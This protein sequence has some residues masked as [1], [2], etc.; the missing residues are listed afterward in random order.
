MNKKLLTSGLLAGLVA[1]SGAGLILQSTGF[2][3]AAAAPAAVV[4][5]ATAGT[6]GTAG[7]TDSTARPDPSA[8]LTE[9][10]QPLVDDGTITADQL[11]AIVGALDAAGPMGR[12]GDGPGGRGMGMGGE[13]LTAVAEVLGVTEA[14]LRT[15]LQGGQTLADVAA[16]EGVEVQTVIDTLV[17]AAGTHLAEHVTAGDLTQEEADAKLT[18]LTT[19][20]SDAVN[21]G[22]PIGGGR[23]GEMGGMG[24]M[25]GRGGHGARGDGD[26]DRDGDD[27]AAGTTEGTTS[28]GVTVEDTTA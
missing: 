3:G 11:T 7:T 9:V 20:I 8:R 10:L 26:R 1:G 13:G 23:G 14:D 16:A 21:N 25:G 24:G 6:T 5:D 4:V 28:R 27:A 15:A 22:G 17:T 12:G 2:A 19:R 18:E